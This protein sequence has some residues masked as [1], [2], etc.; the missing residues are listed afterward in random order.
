MA[1]ADADQPGRA[2]AA[3]HRAV[4]S[5]ERAAS[6]GLARAGRVFKRARKRVG[7]LRGGGPAT[8]DTDEDPPRID[9][10]TLEWLEKRRTTIAT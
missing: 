9:D 3:Q 4:G 8:G 1:A 6:D 2:V 7:T 10:A 5:D